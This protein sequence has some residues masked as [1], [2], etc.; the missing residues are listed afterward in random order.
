MKG[1]QYEE[2]FSLRE[3]VLADISTY[4]LTQETDNIDFYIQQHYKILLFSS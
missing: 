2:I 1:G 4:C 3:R